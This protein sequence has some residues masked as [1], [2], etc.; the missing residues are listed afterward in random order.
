MKRERAQ[1]VHEG[2]ELL[3]DETAVEQ[4]I[5]DLAARVEADCAGDFPL[6]LCVMNGGL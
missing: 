5:A 3:F 4:G 2:A 1:Q 6:V